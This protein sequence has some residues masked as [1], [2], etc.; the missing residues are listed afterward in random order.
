MAIHGQVYGSVGFQGVSMTDGAGT[1]SQ[2]RD[3][4]ALYASGVIGLSAGVLAVA[5]P[6][7]HAAAVAAGKVS[8]AELVAAGVDLR[9]CQVAHNRKH[10][11][12]SKA[13]AQRVAMASAPSTVEA[14]VIAQATADERKALQALAAK[15]KAKRA[16]DK[17]A[18]A[19][20]TLSGAE[21]AALAASYGVAVSV[22]G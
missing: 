1:V 2:G 7:D 19:G 11:D 9:A 4:R 20:R 16:D 5:K 21:L 14:T 8:V 17:A 6:S 15:R 18:K 22:R 12:G 3:L 13:R 10:G